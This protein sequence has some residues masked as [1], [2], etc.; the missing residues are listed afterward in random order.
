MVVWKNWK[1]M[2]QTL[3]IGPGVVP[4][5]SDLLFSKRKKKNTKIMPR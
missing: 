5:T 3:G 2:Q 1:D 4:V